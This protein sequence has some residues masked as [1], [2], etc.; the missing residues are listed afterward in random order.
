MDK[1]WEFNCI[2]EKKSLSLTWKAWVNALIPVG[3][4]LLPGK[5]DSYLKPCKRDLKR[6]QPS[7]LSAVHKS[8]NLVKCIY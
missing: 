6:N 4:L 8:G 7:S 2:S 3:H 1:L 5:L